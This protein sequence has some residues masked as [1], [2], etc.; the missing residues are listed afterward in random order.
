MKLLYA[1]RQAPV[2]RNWD[3][4]APS[5]VLP[6]DPLVAGYWDHA[7]ARVS[8]RG[9]R[10]MGARARG[11]PGIAWWASSAILAAEI[12]GS[13]LA[14]EIGGSAKWASWEERLAPVESRK[15]ALASARNA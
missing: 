1:A 10:G 12:G 5:G 6:V 8:T 3:A 13:A 14:A 7:G 4:P 9:E 11:L 15:F 2:S